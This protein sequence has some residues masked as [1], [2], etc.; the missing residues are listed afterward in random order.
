[1]FGFFAS[2][3][4]VFSIFFFLFIIIRAALSLYE[5]FKREFA[6][7]LN[8]CIFITGSLGDFGFFFFFVSAIFNVFFFFFFFVFFF[9]ILEFLSSLFLFDWFYIIIFFGF[10]GST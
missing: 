6:A 7:L 1:M 4:G 9:F 2:T 3:F 10:D 8:S 5:I